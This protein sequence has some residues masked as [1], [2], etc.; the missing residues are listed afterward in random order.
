MSGNGA[1]TGMAITRRP[2]SRT[3]AVQSSGSFRVLR[4]GSWYDEP[5][6]VRCASRDG[7]TPE[8]RRNDDGFRL[9]LE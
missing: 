7:G 2:R 6:V 9:V 4:G 3:L 8:G 1:A 5:S